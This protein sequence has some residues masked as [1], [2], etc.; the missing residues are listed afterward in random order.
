[1]NKDVNKDVNKD[2]KVN[3]NKSL[4]YSMNFFRPFLVLFFSGIILIIAGSVLAYSILK[5]NIE[6]DLSKSFIMGVSLV[7]YSL[8]FNSVVI[9]FNLEDRIGQAKFIE[10]IKSEKKF[11]TVKFVLTTPFFYI[12]ALI[13]FVIVLSFNLM[14]P[15]VYKTWDYF[16]KDPIYYIICFGLVLVILVFLAHVITVRKWLKN[17]KGVLDDLKNDCGII[18]LRTFGNLIKITLIYSLGVGIFIMFWPAVSPVITVIGENGFIK[19]I[20]SIL[21]LILAVFSIFVLR[22]FLKRRTFLKNLKKYCEENSLRLSEIV[23]P[24]KSIIF[25]QEGFNFTVKK[26]GVNYDCKIISNFFPFSTMI[27]SY[28]GIGLKHVLFR[29]FSIQFFELQKDFEFSFKS[30]NRKILL[31]IP[32][33]KKIFVSISDSKLN[34][35]DVGERLGEYTVHSETSFLNA[36]DR[37]CV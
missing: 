28:K 1:M 18:S 2:A 3:D 36:L 32:K 35:G 20:V 15:F 34:E 9:N 31:V 7:L 11:N 21:L 37:D 23:N 19:L 6:N 30:D 26:N 24:Y 14:L 22:S 25:N 17:Y 29:F 10:R 4:N 13:I 16:V 33:S 12:E 5:Y 27:L 8:I